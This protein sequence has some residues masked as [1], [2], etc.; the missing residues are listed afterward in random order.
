MY[1]WG[2]VVFGVWLVCCGLCCVVGVMWCIVCWYVIVIVGL[3]GMI[4][5]IYLYWNRLCG[6][7]I[8]EKGDGGD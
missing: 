1:L 2:W 3:V 5:V 4:F 6:F 7:W 8:E